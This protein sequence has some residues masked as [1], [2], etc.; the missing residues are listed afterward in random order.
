MGSLWAFFSFT[1]ILY[2]IFASV[3]LCKKGL[4][5]IILLF[6]LAIATTWFEVNPETDVYFVNEELLPVWMFH[7]G[8]FLAGLVVALIVSFAMFMYEADKAD[9]NG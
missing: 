8:C 3:L 9:Q 2:C 6:L 4:I 5:Y 1:G 7:P